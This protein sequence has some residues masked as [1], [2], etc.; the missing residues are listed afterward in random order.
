MVEVDAAAHR[1]LMRKALG[2]AR[3]RGLRGAAAEDV[4][5]DAVSEACAK[6]DPA[7]GAK[8]STL[9]CLMAWRAAAVLVKRLH[10]EVLGP[11][12]QAPDRPEWSAHEALAEANPED[13]E[14]AFAVDVLLSERDPVEVALELGKTAR[15]AAAEL[16]PS[17]WRIERV[18]R[19]LGFSEDDGCP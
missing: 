2:A 3:R 9:A 5:T 8:L 6:W 17:R 12:V 18:L 13:P 14:L 16:G 19:R 15:W 10:P 1:V 7:K 4:A 11:D